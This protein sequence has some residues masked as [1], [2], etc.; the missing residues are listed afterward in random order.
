M[1]N[2]NIDQIYDRTKSYLFIQY[3]CNFSPFAINGG[4]VR[5]RNHTNE[6]KNSAIDIA[7]VRV[8]EATHQEKWSI[9]YHLLTCSGCCLWH[10]VWHV[11]PKLSVI[12]S[13]ILSF[14]DLCT[15]ELS[16]ILHILH[17]LHILQILHILHILCILHILHI[18]HI[19]HMLDILNT[20]H[21]L[22][23]WL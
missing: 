4:S 14:I 20:L 2:S 18:L 12:P 8:G 5:R 16:H 7:R 19:I 21:I 1:N 23:Y 13:F 3:N 6:V 22:F 9:L 17:T 11:W 10:D 15:D